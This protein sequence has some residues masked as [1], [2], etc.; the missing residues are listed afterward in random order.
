ML[1]C[2]QHIVLKGSCP[3]S[4][5]CWDRLGE[6]LTI[7]H[8]AP[9]TLDGP[10]PAVP[11]FLQC[12]GRSPPNKNWLV[13]FHLVLDLSSLPPCPC[14]HLVS[15]GSVSCCYLDSPSLLSILMFHVPFKWPVCPQLT[16]FTILIFLLFPGILWA[17][18]MNEVMPLSYFWC[19]PMLSISRFW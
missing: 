14:T 19:S 5:N 7:F 13:S 4:V 1:Y 2:L 15:P 6:L 17:V 11:S 10:V 8:N 3:Q 18:V 12:P 16:P 9:V